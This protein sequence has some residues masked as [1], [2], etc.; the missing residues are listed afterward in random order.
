[1]RVIPVILVPTFAFAFA[2]G[3]QD[4]RTEDDVRPQPDNAVQDVQDVCETAEPDETGRPDETKRPDEAPRETGEQDVQPQEVVDPEEW[5]KNYGQAC[6]LSERVGKF[7]IMIDQNGIGAIGPDG[8]MNRVETGKVLQEKES[9]GPCR[10]LI[11]EEPECDP[12]CDPQGE[13]CNFDLE[14]EPLPETK[15][16]GTVTVTGLTVPV[17]L[18][19]MPNGQYGKWD[20]E[21]KPFEAGSCIELVAEGD[22]IEGFALQGHGVEM[23]EVP[24]MTLDFTT[25]EPFSVGWTPSDGPGKIRITINLAQHMLVPTLICEVEDIGSYTVPATMTAALVSYGMQGAVEA[26][27]YRFTVDSVEIEEGCVEMEI[28]TRKFWKLKVTEE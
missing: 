18:E 23:I 26:W 27:M 15:S 2:C 24:D 17:E 20:F 22:E 28:Q 5:A 11:R 14:C 10:F 25:G 6:K 4:N 7:P 8:V 1:M 12:W 16:V 3:G 9:E 21:E 13:Q 19:M